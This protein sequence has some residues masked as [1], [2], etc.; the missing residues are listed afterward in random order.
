MSLTSKIT[1]MLSDELDTIPIGKPAWIVANAIAPP[2]V[3]RSSGDEL[4]FVPLVR[5]RDHYKAIPIPGGFNRDAWDY[6]A[7]SRRE[8]KRDEGRYQKADAVGVVFPGGQR[9]LIDPTT[10]RLVKFVEVIH[11]TS[12][13]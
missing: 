7:K 12:S 8:L 1:A 4:G 11:A 9:F 6:P 3:D 5:L 10:H 13:S 2:E